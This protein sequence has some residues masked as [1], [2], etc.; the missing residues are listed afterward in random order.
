MKILF[1]ATDSIAVP[2]LEA[3]ANEGLVKAVFTAPDAPGKRGKSLI[4]TP[5]KVKALELGLDVYTPEHLRSEE[6]RLVESL[7][8]DTLLSFCYGRIFGPKFLSL[9]SRTFNVH[10]SPLPKYRGCSPIYTAIRSGEKESAISIQEIALG[11]DEGDLYGVLPFT[12]DGTETNESLEAKVS[13]MTPSFVL[14]VLKNIDKVEKT[15]QSGESS[16]TG[17]IGKEDGRLDFSLPASVLHATIRACYPWPKAYANLG[18][19]KLMLTGVFGSSFDAFEPCTEEPG[20]VVSLEKKKGLKIATGDGYL[21][22]SRVLPPGKKEMDAASY[23][24][25]NRTIIGARLV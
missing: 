19:E 8:V 5:I 16:Y 7:G 4:P 17:F 20:T 24:N 9:F 13:Q 3:L 12:L 23:V 21:Y 25:G 11:I 1:A 6:R 18:E 22:V 15:P 14:G 10:P 2:L